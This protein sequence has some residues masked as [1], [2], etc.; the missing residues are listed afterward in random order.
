MHWVAVDGPYGDL[1]V[2]IE[3]RLGGDG[4]GR[5]NVSVCHDDSLGGIHDKARGLSGKKEGG[6]REKEKERKPLHPVP[7]RETIHWRDG[8]RKMPKVPKGKKKKKTPG[9][10]SHLGRS[11]PLSI[12]RG[13]EIDPDRHNGLD[14]VV[15][16]HLPLLPGGRTEPNGTQFPGYRCSPGRYYQLCGVMV[17]LRMFLFLGDVNL[18]L[19]EVLGAQIRRRGGAGAD[20]GGQAG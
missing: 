2:V 19:V 10:D 1:L 17:L 6:N 15:E 3:H 4:V 16:G 11:G 5:H 14:T 18:V 20:D 13:D 8:E 9:A 12:K 7:S